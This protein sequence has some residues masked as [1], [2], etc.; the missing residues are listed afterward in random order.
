[1]TR[2]LTTSRCDVHVRV[3]VSGQADCWEP[4]LLPRHLSD[5]LSLIAR[6]LSK[7]KKVSPQPDGV[8]MAD[9]SSQRRTICFD[10]SSRRSG[11]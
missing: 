1:M 7:A 8:F 5:A 2:R 6:F 10:E 11:T 4:L 3:C 9:F